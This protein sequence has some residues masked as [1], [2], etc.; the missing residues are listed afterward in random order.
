MERESARQVPEDVAESSLVTLML[1][2]PS[3]VRRLEGETELELGTL[4][5]ERG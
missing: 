5:K 4:A 1:R 2:F 3:A